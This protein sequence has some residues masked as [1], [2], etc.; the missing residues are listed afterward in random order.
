MPTSI[1]MEESCAL[2]HRHMPSKRA[3]SGTFLNML[4]ELKFPAKAMPTHVVNAILFTHAA[5]DKG[6]QDTFARFIT[7]GDLSIIMSDKKRKAVIEA[8]GILMRAKKLAK[9]VEDVVGQEVA[10]GMVGRLMKDIVVGLAGKEKPADQEPFNLKE[11]ALKF[12]QKIC[13]AAGKS[14]VEPDEPSSIVDSGD[15]AKNFVDYTA[16]GGV[17]SIGKTTVLNASFH[18]GDHIR[19]KKDHSTNMTQLK[20]QSISDSGTVTVEQTD[21]EGKPRQTKRET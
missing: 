12:T 3:V 1:F 13:Q 2:L 5:S 9:D 8:D 21:E 16:E 19:V 7:K 11:C 17:A 10:L 18:V 4:A 20:V 15:P 6:V 14:T